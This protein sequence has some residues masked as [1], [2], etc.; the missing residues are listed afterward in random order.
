MLDWDDLRFFLAIA[1]TGSL[2]A[3]ARELRVTQS[4]VGRRLA[5]LESGLG[6]RLLHRT[7]DGY[8]P[9][10][11]GEAILGQVERVETEVLAVERTTGGHDALLEGVVRVTAVETLASHVLIPAFCALQRGTPEIGI[12]L[13]ADVRHLSLAMRE[14]DIALRLT[15]FEQHD[16]VTRRIGTMAH[17]LYASPAYLNRYGAP[18]FAAGCPGHRLVTGLDGAEVT[19]AARWMTEAAPRAAVALQTDSPEAQLQAALCGEGM[20]CLSR[21][22]GDAFGAALLRLRSPWPQ[23]VVE[24]WLAVHKDNRRTPRIRLV[25]DAVTAAV[26]DRASDLD[27]PESPGPVEL[28]A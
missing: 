25:L 12:E 26:R 13:L 6:T 16:L 4:T 21:L 18:D 24:I 22:R 14:A 5:S 10:L 1:R 9:T 15:R 28:V 11:A 23:A 8:V 17:G 27:P 2:S 19:Q 7:P 3:A 20:A